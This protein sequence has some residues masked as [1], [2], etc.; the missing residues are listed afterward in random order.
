MEPGDFNC[1]QWI[2]FEIVSPAVLKISRQHPIDKFPDGDGRHV[3]V[4][5]GRVRRGGEQRERRGKRSKKRSK[6]RGKTEGEGNT[7]HNKLHT[8]THTQQLQH[9][10]IARCV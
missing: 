10:G 1:S 9:E 2:S 7:T 8:T 4:R 3:Q 5:E 6:K